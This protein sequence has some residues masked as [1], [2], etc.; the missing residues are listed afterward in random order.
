MYAPGDRGTEGRKGDKIVNVT[1]HK[2][3]CYYVLL[4][5]IHQ[6]AYNGSQKGGHLVMLSENLK[7]FRK[8]K[9]ISQE[10]LAVRLNV[11]RQTIS[12][13]EKGLTVPDADTLI[14]I[15]EI[16]EV[17][18]SELLGAKVNGKESKDTVINV[19]EQLSRINEQLAIKNRRSHRIWKTIAIVVVSVILL[20]ILLVIFSLTAIENVTTTPGEIH[21]SEEQIIDPDD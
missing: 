10:E 20:N 8:S 19:A 9:G 1:N 14:R 18:V 21:A 13:W 11:V 6:R 17:D 15:A 4:A 16:L 2:R 12:K 7:S 3:I 5:A